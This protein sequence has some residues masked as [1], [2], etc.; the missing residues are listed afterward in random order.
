MKI[1]NLCSH[2]VSSGY[3]V[4]D[5]HKHVHNTKYEHAKELFLGMYWD[6]YSIFNVFIYDY[7]H[8]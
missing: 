8:S 3:K 4:I 6:V 7:W 5:C 1:D 2:I